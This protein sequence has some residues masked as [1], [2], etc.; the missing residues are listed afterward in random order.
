MANDK[1]FTVKNGLN[2]QNISFVDDITTPVN[3]I[4][5]SML[6][7][8]ALSFSGNSGQLFSITDS[9]TGTIFAVND[10]SGVPSIEVDDDGTIRLAEF[11]GNVLIGTATD[12]GL[13]R[14]QLNGQLH[15]IGTGTNVGVAVDEIRYSG[16]G[17][18]GNRGA[19]YLTN[20]GGTVSIGV[21]AIHNSDT[22]MTFNTTVNTSSKNLN[23]TGNIVAT[24]EV[25]AYSDRRVK[26]NIKTFDNALEKILNSR[27]VTYTRNDTDD[28]ERVQ[29]GVIAQEIQKNFP[30]VVNE[31]TDGTTLTVNYSAMA[32]AFIEAFKDQQTQIDEL[33]ELVQKLSDK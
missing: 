23:V 32:G 10:I 24:G 2:T 8:D 5:M 27:G 4:T 6:G 15:V 13:D 16:Y 31:A 22:A 26:D 25:T 11:S 3:T 1:K 30:E 17:I 18:I 28:K 20:S 21:G 33:K 19:M 12:N 7:G 9:L 29:M 14:L